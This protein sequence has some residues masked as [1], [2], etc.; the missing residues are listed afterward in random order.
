MPKQFEISNIFLCCRRLLGLM[1]SGRIALGGKY[2]A[3]ER[4]IEPTIVVDVKPNDPIME[5]EIFGPILPIYTVENAYDAM[6]FINARYVGQCANNKNS[7]IHHRLSSI[8]VIYIH[9]YLF[10]LSYLLSFV[11]CPFITLT[12]KHFCFAIPAKLPSIIILMK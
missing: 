12:H 10:S 2:D 3:S 1:K 11:L 4:Y 5:E 8:I 6:K 7:S 9:A